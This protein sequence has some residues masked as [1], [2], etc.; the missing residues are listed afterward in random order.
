MLVH[1]YPLFLFRPFVPVFFLFPLA[2]SLSR[3]H[4]FSRQLTA[5][6]RLV[7]LSYENEW[8]RRASEREE[9]TW[10]MEHIKLGKEKE[11]WGEKEEGTGRRKRNISF[12]F[13]TS[14]ICMGHAGINHCKWLIRSPHLEPAS[15]SPLA[16]SLS[17]FPSPSCLIL[18][19]LEGQTHF[20]VNFIMLFELV[21]PWNCDLRACIYPGYMCQFRRE[22]KL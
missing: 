8:N 22:T 2:L 19:K 5:H 1:N 20:P 6:P 11:T 14:D 21:L 4:L 17:P 13:L 7:R 15:P 12:S 3:F 18:K 10:N 9:G 16:L